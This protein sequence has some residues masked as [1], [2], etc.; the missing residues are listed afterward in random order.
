[1]ADH[2]PALHK[3]DDLLDSLKSALAQEADGGEGAAAAMNSFFDS[4]F[5]RL[6]EIDDSTF[7]SAAGLLGDQVAEL[8][9]KQAAM[10]PQTGGCR[11]EQPPP[12]PPAPP[13][14]GVAT[15][16]GGEDATHEAAWAKE[17]GELVAGSAEAAAAADPYA[18]EFED[19]FDPL[20][21]AEQA[22]VSAQLGATDQETL[23]RV[24]AQISAGV[25][26]D[27]E[28]E[29]GEGEGAGAAA[30]AGK[31]GL[32]FVYAS[33]VLN[34]A[35]APLDGE[36]AR[37]LQ[38]EI[39]ELQKCIAASESAATNIA[40]RAF[41]LSQSQTA[42]LS[43]SSSAVGEQQQQQQQQAP[44]SLAL[45]MEGIPPEQQAQLVSHLA[46]VHR[47]VEAERSA[48]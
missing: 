42:P 24:R 9:A 16:E 33:P 15:S 32:Q 10:P 29:G 12:P 11:D 17:Y 3:G 47:E 27:E 46:A 43:D 13:A 20:T 4:V 8:K 37:A 41:E 2:S 6:G 34:R 5:S 30:A 19:C 1:M 44:P 28:E 45:C 7:E 14:D 36:R 22:R 21:P 38:V 48:G 39:K 31:G 40:A 26:S 25:E 23:A 35:G 18:R